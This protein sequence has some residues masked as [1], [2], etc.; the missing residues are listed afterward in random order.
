MAASAL[1]IG[2]PALAEDGVQAIFA[3]E[4]LS[5]GQQYSKAAH[6]CANDAYP[7]EFNC[8]QALSKRA[9]A[10]LAM[11]VRKYEQVAML[12]S[13]EE[14]SRCSATADTESSPQCDGTDIVTDLME[15]QRAWE[16]YRNHQC[17]LEARDS[18]G[19][20][21]ASANY[22][23]CNARLIGNR[24]SNLQ[25]IFRSYEAQFEVQ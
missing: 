4:G 20:W 21:G 24:L 10:Q 25:T 6:F 2:P 1:L 8:A 11:S 17:S 9:E 14:I 22:W 7:N 18:R 12:I 19:G 13:K 15:S 16:L 5:V 23:L 3:D